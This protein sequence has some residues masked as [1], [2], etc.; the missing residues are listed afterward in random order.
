MRKSFLA[1]L[2]N[3][4]CVEVGV[5]RGD[6]AIAMLSSIPHAK[7]YLVDSYDVN[8]S[9]FQ[10]GRIFTLEERSEFINDLKKNLEPFKDRAKLLILDSA[11][12]AKRFPDDYFDFVYIDG[13]HEYISVLNDLKSWF[14]KIKRGGLI[15]G[16]DYG[17]AGVNRA[18]E[19]YFI[20]GVINEAEDWYAIK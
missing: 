9:T 20:D 17:C 6:N 1:F 19:E 18:L 11:E 2:S 3:I 16:H 7:F 13:Q 15:S 10:F 14:P 4:R 12:A 5:G 8:N